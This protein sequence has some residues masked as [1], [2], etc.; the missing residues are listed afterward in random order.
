M[1]A[2]QAI[3]NVEPRSAAAPVA[4][5][6]RYARCISTSKRVRWDI[7]KDVIRGRRFE[8]GKKF[9]PDGLSQLNRVGFL[10]ADDRRLLGQIQGR[11]Y[12]NMFGLVERF[13][14]AKMLELSREHWLRDQT[15]L[16]ALVPG[17]MPPWAAL[18]SLATAIC[19]GSPDI[20][21]IVS[22]S[23]GPSISS[24][25]WSIGVSPAIPAPSGRVVGARGNSSHP[26]TPTVA[27]RYDAAAWTSATP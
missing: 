10:G 9:L 2:A 3:A 8:F 17:M 15:A 24:T 5:L 20:A 13:I 22:L 12:A 4:K 6:D 1:H 11:T 16:E 14:G 21:A 19:T 7:D 27:H 18:S 25:S 26:A 23:S